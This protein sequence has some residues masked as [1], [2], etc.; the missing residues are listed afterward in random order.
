MIPDSWLKERLQTTDV[1]ELSGRESMRL[2]LSDSDFRELVAR[3]PSPQWLEK[4]RV[5][6]SQMGAGDE[7]WFF[8]S[9]P[10]TW[11]GLAGAAGYALVRA[12]RII[13]TVPIRRS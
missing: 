12:G 13:D 9:P 2:G 8:E 5:F 11:A 7:L 6:I 1:Q 10:E 4:W 3:G